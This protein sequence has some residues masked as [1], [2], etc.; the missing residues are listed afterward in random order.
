[1]VLFGRSRI[2][3]KLLKKCLLKE[4][5]WYL[6]LEQIVTSEDD[7]KVLRL[8]GDELISVFFR[9][10]EAAVGRREDVLV[11]EDAS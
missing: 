3:K 7:T 9:L 2:Y 4:M 6:L 5:V 10:H 8:Q 1:M 11:V